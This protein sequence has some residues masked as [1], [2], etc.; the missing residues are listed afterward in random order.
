MTW[1]I[2]PDS[3]LPESWP[4]PDLHLTFTR[5]EPCLDLSLTISHFLL[6]GD[7]LVAVDYELGHSLELLVLYFIPTGSESLRGSWKNTTYKFT[8]IFNTSGRPCR[9]SLGRGSRGGWWPGRWRRPGWWWKGRA[10]K[11]SGRWQSRCQLWGPGTNPVMKIE[12]GW[13]HYILSSHL[14]PGDDGVEDDGHLP[15]AVQTLLDAL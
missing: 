8:N 11:P 6:P 10:N 14:L 12:N 7:E 1:W 3:D 9:R 13:R 4:S 2:R 15:P 5:P